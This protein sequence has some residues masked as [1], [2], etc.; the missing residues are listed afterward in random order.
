[1]AGSFAVPSSDVYA[2]GCS[3]VYVFT[4]LGLAA[5]GHTDVLPEKIPVAWGWAA[6]YDLMVKVP[7]PQVRLSE[8]NGHD[9][10]DEIEVCSASAFL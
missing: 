9:S 1:M 7:G 5:A 8:T 4:N 6:G 10:E 3:D 2:D